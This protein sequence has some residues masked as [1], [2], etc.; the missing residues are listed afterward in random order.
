[1]GVSQLFGP[2][3]VCCAVAVVTASQGRPIARPDQL[4]GAWEIVRG[5]GVDGIFLSISTHVRGTTAQSETASQSVQIRLYHREAGKETWGW[6]VA[7]SPGAQDEPAVLDGEHLR[8]RAVSDGPVI[9]VV[10][11][12]AMQR[13]TGTWSRGGT[14]QDVTLQRPHAAL[15]ALPN[16]LVGDWE[17]L[18]DSVDPWRAPTRLHIYESA[19]GALTAWMDRFI[20]LIDQR[21]GELL[22]VLPGE[23]SAIGLETTSP[24]G[25]GYRFRGTVSADGSTLVGSWQRGDSSGSGTLNAAASFRRIR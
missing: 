13:W 19:D 10:F 5:G 15:V 6:Y 16:H 17:S 7:A 11:D 4:A 1:M 24:G 12:P 18:P 8:L 9:D 23:H 14:S 20:A 2:L 21:H 25:I 3:T 22:Q